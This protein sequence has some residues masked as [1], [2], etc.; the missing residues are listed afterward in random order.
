MTVDEFYEKC[1]EY[2]VEVGKYHKISESG[3]Y[4]KL[5]DINTYTFEELCKALYDNEDYGTLCEMCCPELLKQVWYSR[6]YYWEESYDLEM[7]YI[8]RWIYDCAQNR[9]AEYPT[10]DGK[11]VTIYRGCSREEAESDDYGY[12]WTTDKRIAQWFGAK[13]RDERGDDMVIVTATVS[14]GEIMLDFTDDEEY[15]EKEIVTKNVD[16]IKIEELPADYHNDGLFWERMSDTK[17]V[18]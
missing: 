11:D 6:P 16:V 2:G 12:S 9:E 17:S 15:R 14:L 13:H 10:H 4:C 1:D 3:G 18:A 8:L 7:P 5:D